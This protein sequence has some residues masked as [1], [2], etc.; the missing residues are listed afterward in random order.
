MLFRSGSK[1]YYANADAVYAAISAETLL[2]LSNQP[3]IAEVRPY[4][5]MPALAKGT[6]ISL[7]PAPVGYV[8]HLS[9]GRTLSDANPVLEVVINAYGSVRDVKLGDI[10]TMLVPAYGVDQNGIPFVDGSQ[11]TTPYEVQ[12]VGMVSWPTRSVGWTGP[13]DIP[14]SEQGYVHAPDFHLTHESWQRL[15]ATQSQGQPYSPTAVSLAVSDMGYLFTHS[16]ELR[17]SFPQLS[18]FPISQVA[19]HMLRYGLIDRFYEAPRML[20]AGEYMKEQTF[21]S[22]DFAKLTG[23]L[24]YINARKLMASQMLAA[25]AA[26]RKEI[27]ILKA[28]GARQRE[29]VSLILI[30]AM[31]LALIGAS[32]GF[33][34]VRLAAIHLALTNGAVWAVV[35]GNAAIELGLVLALTCGLAL[36]FGVLPAWRVAKLT[37]ME[38]FRNEIGR[39]HV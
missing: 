13:A 36:L 35:L 1:G 26:R 12:V 2:A 25:V 14:M 5:V 23:I 38:V 33:M 17:E 20:W 11:P 3:G 22:Q 19:Q 15:W 24:L 28:I 39:A 16:K 32:G 4:L 7:R 29:V 9:E 30:E 8:E 21:A 31:F 37:V 18:V 10:I 34:L 27:G 6:Q